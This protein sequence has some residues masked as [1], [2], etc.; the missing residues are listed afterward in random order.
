MAVQNIAGPSSSLDYRIRF[1]IAHKRLIEVKYK[2]F[3]RLAEP[4]DYGSNRTITI[5]MSSTRA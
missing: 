4:H 1:A 5:G 3:A 2:R